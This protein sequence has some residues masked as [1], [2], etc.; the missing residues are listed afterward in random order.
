MNK[1]IREVNGFYNKSK[2]FGYTD[3]LYVE[4][5]CWDVLDNANLVGKNICQG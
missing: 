2:N 5:K 1:F 3:S 4:K